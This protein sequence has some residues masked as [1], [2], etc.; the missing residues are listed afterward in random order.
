M[1]IESFFLGSGV[2]PSA[3]VELKDGLGKEIF[4]YSSGT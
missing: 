4:F 2:E 1:M 3:V